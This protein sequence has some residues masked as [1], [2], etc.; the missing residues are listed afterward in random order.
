MDAFCSF[1]QKLL[2][3]FYEA[4]QYYCLN[5]RRTQ[6]TIYH[7]IRQSRGWSLCKTSGNRAD[8]NLFINVFQALKLVISP[9][10]VTYFC[11]RLSSRTCRYFHPLGWHFQHV[12]FYIVS[13]HLNAYSQYKNLHA[14]F[15]DMY[16]EDIF[17]FK[18]LIY[19]PQIPPCLTM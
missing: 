7:D 11:S 15:Q 4:K 10:S 6:V 14:K 2:K 1:T 9:L 8:Y 13:K 12:G 16:L 19:E 3:E 17:L 5:I 18:K